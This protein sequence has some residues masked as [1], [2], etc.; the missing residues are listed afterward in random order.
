LQ[1]ALAVLG[2]LIIV[3][4]GWFVLLPNFGGKTNS[5]EQTNASNVAHNGNNIP[6][7]AKPANVKP[8]PEFV[9]PANTVRFVNSRTG[10]DG[11]LAEHYVDFSFYYPKNWVRDPA[12]G[13]AG[14][15][16]FAKVDR[17]LRDDLTQENF[18]VGWYAS[19]GSPSTEFPQLVEN[20]SA[21]FAKGFPEYRKV[22]EGPIKVNSI[23]A[24]E[25]R[26][27]SI[28]RNT[29]N[30]DIKVWGRAIFLPPQDGGSN[31]V[32]LLML[33]TSLAPEIRSENDVGIKGQTPVILKSF[34]FGAPPS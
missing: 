29:A 32:S 27:E 28:S 4:I 15:T 6:A 14:A 13:K 1:I 23:D 25:F 22:S 2:L 26:F 16:N 31:G 30:G 20:L 7:N 8:E 3:T 12:A 17:V 34:R 18:A 9:P 19:S 21:Q 33:A 10:L 11:K 24:Y 5:T